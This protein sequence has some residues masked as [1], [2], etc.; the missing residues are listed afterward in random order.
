MIIPLTHQRNLLLFQHGWGKREE[1]GGSEADRQ[2][3]KRTG[4]RDRRFG[5]Q[6]KET[7]SCSLSQLQA[8][9]FAAGV[10]QRCLQSS[11]GRH[12]ESSAIQ[13]DR[14]HQLA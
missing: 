2:I 12:R 1:S 11:H 9:I 14:I 4:G 5:I 6:E 7:S 13:C 10:P 3:F 8:Y